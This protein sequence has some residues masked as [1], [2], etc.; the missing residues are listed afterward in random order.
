MENCVKI[1]QKLGF[2]KIKEQLVLRCSTNYAKE[3]VRGEKVSHNA[4]T[5][6]KRLSLTD[7]MRLI[8]MF[9]SGFPQSGFIDSIEFL[10]PLEVEYSSITLENMN[11]LY[12]FV[13]N[14]KGVLNFFRTCKEGA[15]LNLKAMAEPI[16]FF[17][18]IS[19][20]IEAIVDRFGEVRDNASMELYNIRKSLREKEGSISRKI[21]AI[22]RK[23][24]EEG[25]ADEEASVSVRD[26]RLLIPVRDRK[27]VV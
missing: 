22:L 8:C 10:K 5:I 9:E 21:Q 2:E 3:R 18:E 12:T 14:L 17:P 13:E 24:Q 26:G 19:R 7:E 20:R 16:A 15:Y 11:R 6:G 27:S 1:E 4:R 25:L 23:A